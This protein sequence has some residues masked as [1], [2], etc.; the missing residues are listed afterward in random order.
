MAGDVRPPGD[1]TVHDRFVDRSYRYLQGTNSPGNGNVPPY[2]AFSTS[3]QLSFRSKRPSYTKGAVV[4]LLGGDTFRKSTSYDHSSVEIVTDGMYS[5][6]YWSRH[7]NLAWL[8]KGAEDY[9]REVGTLVSTPPIQSP[10]GIPTD[11]RNEAVTKA[12]NKIADQKINLGE[13]LATLGQTVRLFSSKVSLLHDAIQYG[14]KVKSWKKLL[15][16]SA[17]DLHKAGELTT[18]A[19]EYLAYVYGLKPLMQDVYT[20]H[21]LMRDGAEKTLLFKGVG[22]AHRMQGAKPKTLGPFSN[23][24]MAV[25]SGNYK[26]HVKC[27]VWGQIDPNTQSLRAINQLGLLNP[28][29]L[30]WDLVPFSFCVD[31]ILPI[32][33]VLYA[34]TAPAGLLFVDGSLSCKTEESLL[35]S[36]KT[37]TTTIDYDNAVSNADKSE[38]KMY[39]TLTYEGYT[40]QKLTTWPLPGLWFDTDPFRGD[41]PLKALALSIIALRGTTSPIR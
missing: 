8:Y 32:G 38:R 7:D 13:N 20:A 34:L 33:P 12:L 40:R 19:S 4:T 14:R 22:K 6:F 29:G 28:Y 17:R 15:T 21:K 41:R 11:A 24:K 37:S 18:V 25:L 35:I 10:S 30:A 16:K 31:W 2:G 23:C 5:T 27:V 3:S 9:G 39:V 1:I 26:Q 36:Y